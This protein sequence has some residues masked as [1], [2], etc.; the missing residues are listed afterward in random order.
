VIFTSNLPNDADMI[1][2]LGSIAIPCPLFTDCA[3]WGKNP[4]GAVRYV[5]RIGK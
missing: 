5:G 1:K 2:A 4:D 3:F